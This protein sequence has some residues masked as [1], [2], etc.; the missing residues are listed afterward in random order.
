MKTTRLHSSSSKPERRSIALATA[1]F[2]FVSAAL[3]FALGGTIHAPWAH[4][5]AAQRP[6]PIVIEQLPTPQSTPRPP[7]P[8]PQPTMHTTQQRVSQHIRSKPSPI[9]PAK[10]VGFHP[11]VA[12]QTGAPT[13]VTPAQTSQTQA[14]QPEVSSTPVDARD[15]IVSARFIN[16]VEP[17]FPP[18]AMDQGVEGTV[19]VLI[20]IGPDGVASDVRVWQSSG[21]AALD[22]AA[23]QAAQLST[24]APPEVNGQP[25]TQTYRII[26][27]FY[28]N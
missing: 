14:P 28:L 16:R 20:T 6:M 5:E 18:E 1:A 24:Y 12:Q 11:P 7:R 27:T 17:V 15:I 2:V 22:R 25:A 4:Q 26:Y 10:L 8:T 9:R 13:I 19:I 3:H 23:I 21:N